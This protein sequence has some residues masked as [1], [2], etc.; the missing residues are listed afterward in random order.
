MEHD[1]PINEMKRS[2]GDAAGGLVAGRSAEGV[3]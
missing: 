2:S 3:G 1:F